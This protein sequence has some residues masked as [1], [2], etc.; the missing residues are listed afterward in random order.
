MEGQ[1][2]P[3]PLCLGYTDL[4]LDSLLIGA[5][6][7]RREEDGSVKVTPQ[8][9]DKGIPYESFYD[10]ISNETRHSLDI[11]QVY[12]KLERQHAE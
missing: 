9:L 11:Q 1:K 5:Y 7:L 2:V 12:F 3:V 8:P 6:L 10:V 4:T